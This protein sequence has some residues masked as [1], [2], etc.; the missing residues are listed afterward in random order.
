MLFKL[1]VELDFIISINLF[2]IYLAV[3][4]SAARGVTVSSGTRGGA[5]AA[6]NNDDSYTKT[7]GIPNG[8]V[9]V[10][11]GKIEEVYFFKIKLSYGA[12][13]HLIRI[14]NSENHLENKPCTKIGIPNLVLSTCFCDFGPT[15]GRYLHLTRHTV[16]LS[17]AIKLYEIYIYVKQ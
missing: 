8:W 1:N 2:V 4:R 3:T 15:K 12:G 16:D 11:F 9:R 17:T 5:K 7:D 13:G 6:D 14:G 10:D